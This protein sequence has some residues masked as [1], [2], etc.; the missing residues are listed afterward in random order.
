MTFLGYMVV[1]CQFDQEN[2]NQNNFE[3]KDFIQKM[4]CQPSKESM[5]NDH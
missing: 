3:F 4:W 2:E 1:N 5:E